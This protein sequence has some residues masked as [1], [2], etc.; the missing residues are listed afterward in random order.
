[1]ISCTDEKSVLRCVWSK[2]DCIK[3]PPDN[4]GI[5]M[6][7]ALKTIGL[8]RHLTAKILLHLRTNSFDWQVLTQ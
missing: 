8:Q 5:F 7:L 2:I 4:G 3:K 6:K 1:M